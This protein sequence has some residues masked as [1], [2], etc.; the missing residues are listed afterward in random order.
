M[1]SKKHV[2]G[3]VKSDADGKDDSRGD[4]VR[5]ILAC[6]QVLLNSDRS[7]FRGVHPKQGINGANDLQRIHQPDDL[8]GKRDIS[9]YECLQDDTRQ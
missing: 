9:S 4:G 7:V 2:N 6:K 1:C 8:K 5:K 3:T